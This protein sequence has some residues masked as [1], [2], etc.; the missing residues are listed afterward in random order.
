MD[1]EIKKGK[2]LSKKELYLIAKESIKNF[3]KGNK[4]LKKELEELKDEMNSTFFFVKDKNKMLSFGLLRPVKI[5]YL[6][7]TYNILGIGN[8][9]SIEKKKGYGTILMNEQLK[10]L[11]KKKKTGLGFT[12]SRV[13]KFYEKVGLIAER[14]LRNR[15]F[16]DYGD[17]KTNKE[18]KGWWGVYYEG[19]D[20]FITKVLKTKSIVK[21]PCMHW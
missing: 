8:I 21:I 19:K 10:F 15:F 2:D 12:G 11:K 5:N 14:K 1:I 4:K 6:K 20:K 16:Y 3:D 18:E 9:I 17:S 13:S 7:K